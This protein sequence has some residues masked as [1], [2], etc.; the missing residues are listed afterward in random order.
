[1]LFFVA[2]IILSNIISPY[3]WQEVYG[4]HGL[5]SL[6]GCNSNCHKWK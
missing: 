3:D 2:K 4:V 5:V 6:Y 1:L